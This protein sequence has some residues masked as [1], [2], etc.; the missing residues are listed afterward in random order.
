MSLVHSDTGKKRNVPSFKGGRSGSGWVQPSWVYKAF[1]S[2]PSSEWSFTDGLK[3]PG[4]LPGRRTCWDE[5][6]A[7]GQRKKSLFLK[8]RESLCLKM[9][10]LSGLEPLQ[11]Q[12]LLWQKSGQGHLSSFGWRERETKRKVICKMSKQSKVR[13]TMGSIGAMEKKDS[14]KWGKPH[15]EQVERSWPK[16][17]QDGHLDRA[18]P[19]Q[20]ILENTDC[21]EIS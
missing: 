15:R 19:E 6:P 11:A 18:D 16:P 7:S 8:M 1:L 5:L 10:E 12:E 20:N 9:R 21:P 2:E 14:Q 4:V 13:T 17:A 3:Q